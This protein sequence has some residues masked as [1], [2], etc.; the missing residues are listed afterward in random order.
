MDGD[1]KQNGEAHEAQGLAKVEGADDA[2]FGLDGRLLKGAEAR[3]NLPRR[4]KSRKMKSPSIRSE[5]P[6]V[7]HCRHGH[8]SRGAKPQTARVAIEAADDDLQTH[9]LQDT[10]HLSVVENI[11]RTA[12]QSNPSYKKC[13]SSESCSGRGTRTVRLP[14]EVSNPEG[15]SLWEA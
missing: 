2:L 13:S 8:L 11:L 6:H 4:L 3:H 5:R 7:V 1:I 10:R 14:P 12:D 15:T 9:A